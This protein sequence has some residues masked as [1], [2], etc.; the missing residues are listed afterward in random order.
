[1]TI[2]NILHCVLIGI[3]RLAR[4]FIMNMINM[5]L[6]VRPTTERFSDR[7]PVLTSTI[8]AESLCYLLSHRWCWCLFH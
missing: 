8:N 4:Q 2:L 3:Y 1:M 6:L 7:A 5:L